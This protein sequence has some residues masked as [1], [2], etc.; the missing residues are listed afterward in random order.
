MFIMCYFPNLQ[1]FFI[2]FDAEPRWRDMLKRICPFC[3]LALHVCFVVPVGSQGFFIAMRDIGSIRDK[4]LELRQLEDQALINFNEAKNF[5]LRIRRER[6]KLEK[7][8]TPP[9]N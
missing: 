9:E 1:Y 3:H 6:R 5:L 8:L 2:T 4:L 7:L